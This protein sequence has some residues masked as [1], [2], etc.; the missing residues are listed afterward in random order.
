MFPMSE[1]GKDFLFVIQKK[2]SCKSTG[3]EIQK[4]LALSALLIGSLSIFTPPGGPEKSAKRE[5]YTAGEKGLLG[6]PQ[7]TQ[8][9]CAISLGKGCY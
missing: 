6:N 1:V 8:L 9:R 5:H 2:G 3:E 4:L 7:Y